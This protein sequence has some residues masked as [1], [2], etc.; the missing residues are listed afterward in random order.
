MNS[1]FTSITVLRDPPLRIRSTSTTVVPSRRSI[2]RAMACANFG[3]P[4]IIF[5]H[6][7]NPLGPFKVVPP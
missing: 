1:F 3:A 5:T 4:G 6:S 2:T 7:L